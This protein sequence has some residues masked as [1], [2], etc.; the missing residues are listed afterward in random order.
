MRESVRTCV[1]QGVYACVQWMQ[2]CR[3]EMGFWSRSCREAG[4]HDKEVN[5]EVGVGALDGLGGG[6]QAGALHDERRR[7]ADEDADEGGPRVHRRAVQ[8]LH[9]SH[10]PAPPDPSDDYPLHSPE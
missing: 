1:H 7:H 6:L 5:V 4:A 8:V 2:G 9:L 3:R 10:R